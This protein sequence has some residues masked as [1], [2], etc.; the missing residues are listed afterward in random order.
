[1]AHGR[2]PKQTIWSFFFVSLNNPFD[3]SYE[4]FIKKHI[5]LKM[6]THIFYKIVFF[7]TNKESSRAS[8]NKCPS[9]WKSSSQ[10]I[11]SLVKKRISFAKHLL[12]IYTSLKKISKITLN[13]FSL[14]SSGSLTDYN[15]IGLFRLQVWLMV[16]HW[17]F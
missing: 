3:Q 15:I 10:L 14:D 7:R 8:S 17:L 5:K 1:M 11:V 9:K 4:F 16:C 2:H 12:P 6:N 13:L